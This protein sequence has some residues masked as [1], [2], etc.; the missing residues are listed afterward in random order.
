MYFL[1]ALI[2]QCTWSVCY[3][4]SIWLDELDLSKIRQGWG[5]AQK[6]HSVD[7]RALTIEGKTYERGIGT[8]ATSIFTLDLH[9]STK[10]FTTVA[11]T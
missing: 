3:A 11:E 2:V 7:G 6:G 4:E 9:G 1:L 5:Q 10:E 8:H